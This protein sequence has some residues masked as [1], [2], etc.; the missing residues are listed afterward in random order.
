[1]WH[2]A[3]FRRVAGV[4]QM[5][6]SELKE[7]VCAKTAVF[8]FFRNFYVNPNAYRENPPARILGASFLQWM[9]RNTPGMLERAPLPKRLTVVKRTGWRRIVNGDE[10]VQKARALGW[11]AEVSARESLGRCYEGKSGLGPATVSTGM[12]GFIC[13]RMLEL[14]KGGCTCLVGTTCK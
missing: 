10:F 3:I 14:W 11:Q 4:P 6:V 7:G 9:F 8:M 12:D 13:G 1:M 2:S 5:D